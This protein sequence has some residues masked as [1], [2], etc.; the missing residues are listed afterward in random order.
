MISKS[1]AGYPQLTTVISVQWEAIC[2]L[3]GGAAKDRDRGDAGLCTPFIRLRTLCLA[4]AGR[5]C[6]EQAHKIPG[7]ELP[8]RFMP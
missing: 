6:S 4:R 8:S 1:P 5:R 7:I 2:C 3:L